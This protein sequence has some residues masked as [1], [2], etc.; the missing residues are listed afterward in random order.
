MVI[1]SKTGNHNIHFFDTSEGR[2]GSRVE[3]S[4]ERL[5]CVWQST[6]LVHNNETIMWSVLKFPPKQPAHTRKRISEIKQHFLRFKQVLRWVRRDRK[7]KILVSM[8]KTK[9]ITTAPAQETWPGEEFVCCV[10]PVSCWLFSDMM[11]TIILCRR[12]FEFLNKILY[13]SCGVFCCLF[14]LSSSLLR[15]RKGG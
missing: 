14:A 4:C 9:G 6:S 8:G 2:K 1:L 15:L 7:E 11:M 3:R 10:M 12:M 5:L 13:F